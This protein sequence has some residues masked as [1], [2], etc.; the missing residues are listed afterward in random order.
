MLPQQAPPRLPTTTFEMMKQSLLFKLCFA[1]AI[2]CVVAVLALTPAS[3]LARCSS[4]RSCSWY[5]GSNYYECQY[6]STKYCCNSNYATTCGGSY[7]YT[8]YDYYEPC[9]GI[10]ITM[11]VC[12]A[13]S[14][15]LTIGV[16]IMWCNFRR[17]V[18][19]PY[20]NPGVNYVQIIDPTMNQYQQ[21]F[22]GYN[23]TA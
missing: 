5:Y 20:F 12:S 2:T 7:C 10:F 22:Y 4:N 15:F 16:F 23:N 11:W 8:K 1:G 18:Q 19:N 21:P 14:F 17:R 13:L 3:V 9:W 6:Y